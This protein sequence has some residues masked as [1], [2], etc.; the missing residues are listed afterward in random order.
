MAAAAGD[1]LEGS[2]QQAAA[3]KNVWAYLFV[4]SYLMS[5]IPKLALTD[6]IK[7]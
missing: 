6:F 1:L 2:R 4:H 3:S 5:E 7:F